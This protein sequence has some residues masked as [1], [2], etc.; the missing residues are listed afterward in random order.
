MTASMQARTTSSDSSM[1]PVGRP[2]GSTGNRARA[3]VAPGTGLPQDGMT[4]AGGPPQVT[5]QTFEDYASVQHAVDRLADHGF[6]VERVAIVGRDLRYVEQVTGRMTVGT[7]AMLAA[8]HG[9]VIGS[10]FALGF[11]LIF[12]YSPNPALPLLVLYG[13][14]AGAVLGALFGAASHA[15]RNGRRAFASVP[16]VVADRYD[17]L[18]DAGH[19]DRAAALLRDLGPTADTGPAHPVR[20]PARA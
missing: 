3:L 18:V 13:I 1:T 19:A 7:A 11:G 5:L 12:T 17:L 4:N 8:L 16:S 10:L 9:A 6:P 15:A 20:R 14:V 2:R